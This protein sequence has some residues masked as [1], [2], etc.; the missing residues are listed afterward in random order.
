MAQNM[1]GLLSGLAGFSGA[2]SHLHTASS[3]ISALRG[4]DLPDTAPAA[5]QGL[6]GFLGKGD[7]RKLQI[8]FQRLTDAEKKVLT[9]FFNWHFKGENIQDRL[10]AMWYLGS[11]RVFVT[12]IKGA[13]VP[14]GTTK[15]TTTPPEKDG[16]KVVTVSDK[17]TYADEYQY[18]FE[19][20]K[21]IIRII[22][23]GK[24]RHKKA[25]PTSSEEQ[26]LEAGYAEVLAYFRATGVPHMPPKSEQ[27]WWERAKSL[28]IAGYGELSEW[29]RTG[30]QELQEA[31][32]HEMRQMLHPTWFERFILNP[33][34]KLFSWS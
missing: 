34:L 2:L 21:E 13:N 17:T 24:A 8:L 5:S 15:T 19:F 30:R 9:G 25:F 28:G 6:A 22:R 27:D 7:E 12:G 16:V 10:I 18:S 20:L 26:Q 32:G 11:F 23:A 3:I 1:R 14:I 29:Y 33:F 31:Y 4:N